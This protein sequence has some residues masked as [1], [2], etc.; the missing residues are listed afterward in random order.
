MK[1]LIS[2]FK[3]VHH[4]LGDHIR[5]LLGNLLCLLL[6]ERRFG[7]HLA[8]GL[9]MLHGFI[10]GGWQFVLLFGELIEQQADLI[11]LGLFKIQFGDQGIK[12]FLSLNSCRG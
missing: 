3:P 4:A 7:N 2:Q 10:H 6:V 5:N 8:Y 12:R 11:D 9:S 1:N